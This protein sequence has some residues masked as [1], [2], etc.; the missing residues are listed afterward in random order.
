M[1]LYSNVTSKRLIY[2]QV[3]HN[4]AA[5]KHVGMISAF[6]KK[7]WNNIDSKKKVKSF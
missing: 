1:T 5:Y 4:L 2:Y 3:L 7:S 6:I